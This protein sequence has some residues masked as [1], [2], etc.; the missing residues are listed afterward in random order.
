MRSVIFH[1]PPQF[2]PVNLRLSQNRPRVFHTHK[3]EQ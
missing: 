1:A 3:I 2:N